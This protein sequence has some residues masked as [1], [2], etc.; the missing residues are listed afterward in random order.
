LSASGC[1][2][3]LLSAARGKNQRH[4]ADRNKSRIFCRKDAFEGKV[5]T[6]TTTLMTAAP[7]ALNSLEKNMTTHDY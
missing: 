1:W 5:V 7:S 6:L 4:Q 2:K 3:T